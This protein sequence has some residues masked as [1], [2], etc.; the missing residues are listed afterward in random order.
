MPI[1]L[2]TKNRRDS[3]IFSWMMMTPSHCVAVTSR[4]RHRIRRE[5]RPGLVL[6][7][8]HGAAEVAPD[9]HLLVLRDDEVLALDAA[10]DAEPLEAHERGA[11]VL[12]AGALDA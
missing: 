1:S 8:R 3:N 7:L 5:G 10:D 12:D 11:E 2:S 9:D 6:E 4:D